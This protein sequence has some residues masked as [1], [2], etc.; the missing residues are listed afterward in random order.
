MARIVMTDDGLPFDGKS[1]ETGPLGGAETAFVLLAEA[2]A[3]RGHEV[4]ARTGCRK[5]LFY[6]GIDWAPLSRGAPE[7]ADLHIANR[8]HRVLDLVPRARR[9]AFW[10]H[11]PA[12]Y[13]LKWRYLT[14]LW[15]HRPIMVFLGPHH[16]RTYPDWAPG[17]TR[18]TIPLGLHEAFRQGELRANPPPPRAVFTSHPLRGL[19]WL[20]G[21]WQQR[22]R[23]AAPKAELLVFSGAA[24]YGAAGAAKAG[25][26]APVLE[27]ARALLGE[28]VVLRPP[29]DR[30]ALAEELSACRAMLYRGDEGETFCLAVAEAQAIGVPAV[31][32]PIGAVAERV[33]DGETGFVAASDEAF[34]EA[35]IRV[36]TDDDLWRRQHGAAIARQRGR[37]WNH[38][39][40]DFERLMTS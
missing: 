10:I 28:G 24:T 2:L 22:I 30:A 23:P 4:L 37:S 3:A 7:I 40:G 27:R 29:L 38:V 11:N 26:I 19:D 33:I 39:A 6:H 18:M 31:V 36:L 14:R 16:R 34:A 13:L 35:A 20:L 12:R 25:Q 21:I 5:P 1:V 9:L 32:Q 17:G 15:R 8:G